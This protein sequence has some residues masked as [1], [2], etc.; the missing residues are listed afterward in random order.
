MHSIPS[1]CPTLTCED[2]AID[3]TSTNSPLPEEYKL[4]WPTRESN[5]EPRFGVRV[6]NWRLSLLRYHL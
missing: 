2:Q 5:N 6:D 4:G 3:K 1:A